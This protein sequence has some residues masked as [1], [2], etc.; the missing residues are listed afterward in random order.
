MYILE[1]SMHLLKHR[2]A[3]YNGLQ[4]T[5]SWSNLPLKNPDFENNLLLGFY[6]L[7]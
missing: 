1:S 5:L 7:M 3:F 2:Q 4:V 6:A